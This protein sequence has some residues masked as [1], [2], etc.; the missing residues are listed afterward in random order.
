MSVFTSWLGESESVKQYRPLRFRVRISVVLQEAGAALHC[1]EFTLVQLE[2]GHSCAEQKREATLVSLPTL[3]GYEAVC[4]E[5][6]AV[7]PD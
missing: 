6:L 1:V 5:S 3:D 2:M 4:Q 7:S